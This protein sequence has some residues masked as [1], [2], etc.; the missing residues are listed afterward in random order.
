MGDRI[1][2]IGAGNMGS[3]LIK[4]V[5]KS[6]RYNPENV[7]IYDTDSDKQK[8]ICNETGASKASSAADLVDICGIVVLA[9]K[10]NMVKNALE[11]TGSCFSEDKLLVSIAAGISIKTLFDIVGSKA[12]I[13]R[14]MP[15][16][17]T[18]VGEG[19][20]II[21]PSENVSD[22][23]VQEIKGLFECV[24]RTEQL[25]EEL[26]SAV[27]SLSGSS[28]AYV[29]IL[30]EAMADAAVR[31]GIKRDAA[32]RIG[33]QAVLGSAKL[34]LETGKHPGVLKDQ[35]CSPG[36]TTIEAVAVLEEKG[37]RDAVIEAMKSCYDKAQKMEAG[38]L[39]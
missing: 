34:A 9:V 17:P 21:S 12:K 38:S 39:S 14:T 27:T 31:F 29:F 35:V 1:G 25:P 19:M 6:G 24:G 7:Y 32:Y 16:T 10:P 33:A 28:P 3:A 26:M 20:T 23:E 36:G 11:G 22:E 8:S 4:G 18:L 30:L 15:N 37:F 13:I 5:L 2:F